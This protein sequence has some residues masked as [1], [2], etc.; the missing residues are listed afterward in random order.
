MSPTKWLRSRRKK[1]RKTVVDVLLHTRFKVID[2]MLQNGWISARDLCRM[3]SLNSTFKQWI[4]NGGP[5]ETLCCSRF[6]NSSRIPETFLR[7]FGGFK[8]LYRHRISTIGNLHEDDLSM[9]PPLPPPRINE[10]QVMLLVDISVAGESAFSDY[11]T[12]KDLTRLLE[13]G[14]VAFALTKPF[15]VGKATCWFD[16]DECVCGKCHINYYEYDARIHFLRKNN[17]GSLTSCCVYQPSYKEWSRSLDGE[18]IGNGKYVLKEDSDTEEWLG[19]SETFFGSDIDERIEGL[20]IKKTKNGARVEQRLRGTVCFRV[21]IRLSLEAPGDKISISG[22]AI[23]I[24]RREHGE[25]EWEVYDDSVEE[26][27]GVSIMHVLE[28]LEGHCSRN[29]P[30]PPDLL[31]R[32]YVN[33][34][35]A[36][37]SLT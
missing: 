20:A 28:V 11:F 34:D 3:E 6:P 12:G 5:W 25:D 18:H 23:E 16:E 8:M 22:F 36:I 17:N 10:D 31:S 35:D 30:P 7:S 4:R 26:E 9:L 33:Y 24:V 29:G 32:E 14:S 2:V 19:C 1:K 27:T 21:N 13:E 15:P 37:V